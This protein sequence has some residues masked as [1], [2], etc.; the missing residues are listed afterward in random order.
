MKDW[1]KGK[2]AINLS[3]KEKSIRKREKG[4]RKVRENDERFL[5]RES[6]KKSKKEQK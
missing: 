3:E 5:E 2:A 6:T 1:V 4:G